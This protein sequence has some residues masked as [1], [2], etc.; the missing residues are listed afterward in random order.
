MNK[1]DR[2]WFFQDPYPES[3]DCGQLAAL[4]WKRLDPHPK[5]SYGL[6]A[7]EGSPTASAFSF[8][9]ITPDAGVERMNDSQVSFNWP[10]REFEPGMALAETEK[11]ETA[12]VLA[13]QGRR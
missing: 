9:A 3:F 10:P 1:T 5:A 11:K 12:P 7:F 13:D 8:Y 4:S 6:L 2:K